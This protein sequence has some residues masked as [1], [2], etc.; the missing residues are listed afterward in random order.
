M[1]LASLISA[2]PNL[3]EILAYSAVGFLVVMFVLAAQSIMTSLMGLIFTS[4]EK[5]K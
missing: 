1:L 2:D 4:I 5:N 3:M